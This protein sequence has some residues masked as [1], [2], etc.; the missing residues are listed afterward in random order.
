MMA[1]NRRY[2]RRDSKA[3]KTGAAIAA[4]ALVGGGAIAAVA[5]ATGGH[6]AASAANAAYSHRSGHSSGSNLGDMLSSA[7]K[8][9]GSSRSTSYSDLASMTSVR[10]YSQ[11]SH[12]GSTEDIQRGIVVLA[13]NQFIVLQSA[14]GTD[15]L[16]EVSGN[17]KFEDASSSTS[18]T[19]ALTASTSA[20]TA[21]ME[22]G[23]MIP[24]TTLLAGSTT[25]AS[26]MLTPS[27]T[28]QTYTVDVAGTDLTV[29]IT[30]TKSTATV[31]STATTTADTT[32]TTDPT[33]STEST[34]ATMDGLARGDLATIAGTRSHH[35]L[36]AELVLFDPLSTSDVGGS[37]AT[38][39][40]A[41]STA[42]PTPT[43]TATSDPLAPFIPASTPSADPTHW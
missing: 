8:D 39:A 35:V 33:T 11:T 9:W 18:A 32:P 15:R 16:W 41:A 17:T 31:S 40:H 42:D 2:G 21:A 13:T 12:Q 7:M 36:Q 5:L 29:T 26:A 37:T 34:T 1:R 6:S 25:T 4:T 28:S 14:N 24:A 22:S 10:D 19:D 43:A 3:V 20:T 23:D 27:S 30:V 38:G